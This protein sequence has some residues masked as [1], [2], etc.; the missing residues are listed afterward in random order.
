MSGQNLTSGPVVTRELKPT[1]QQNVPIDLPEGLPFYYYFDMKLCAILIGVGII[2]FILNIIFS[3]LMIILP[4]K[5]KKFKCVKCRRE[6]T[7]LRNPKICSI[8]RG[9]I[10]PANEYTEFNED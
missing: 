9:R 7:A 6:I 5:L 1:L 10:V 2:L 3:G 8:C 4:F